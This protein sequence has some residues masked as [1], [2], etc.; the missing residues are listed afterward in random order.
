MIFVGILSPPGAFFSLWTDCL[1]IAP[2]DLE[3]IGGLSSFDPGL[4][5]WIGARGSDEL[6]VVLFFTA[7]ENPSVDVGG[8][9]KV[10]PGKQILVRKPVMDRFGM[11]GFVSSGRGR[12]YVG[13]QRRTFIVAG[14]GQMNHVSGSTPVGPGAEP[15]LRIVRR[16]QDLRVGFDLL[17]RD[18][19]SLLASSCRRS[20]R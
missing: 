9:C 7:E 8:I 17:R 10:L 1:P 4:P 12:I 11:A 6:N 20:R 18:K 13:N 19:N 2:V 16:L 15:S 14:L 5:A 3:L